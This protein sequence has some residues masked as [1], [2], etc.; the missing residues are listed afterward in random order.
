MY[1]PLHI[2]ISVKRL[3]AA[4]LVCL[5]INM[6]DLTFKFESA[7][8]CL[9]PE[10]RFIG[11]SP[12]SGGELATNGLIVL[13]YSAA[14]FANYQVTVNGISARF[15]LVEL[16]GINRQD[17]GYI[18]PAPNVGDQV[19]LTIED[20]FSGNT[21]INYTITEANDSQ[22]PEASP[23]AMF[24]RDTAVNSDFLTSCDPPNLK[25]RRQERIFAWLNEEE[26]QQARFIKYNGRIYDIPELNEIIR[27]GQ[28]YQEWTLDRYMTI[29][30]EIAPAPSCTSFNYISANGSISEDI[31]ICTACT[32]VSYDNMMMLTQRQENREHCIHHDLRPYD[33]LASDPG[34]ELEQ[35]GMEAGAEAGAEG[36]ADAG[37]EAGAEAGVEAG[38]ESG[39]EAGEIVVNE[40]GI[41]AG[42]E[43]SETMMDQQDLLE[44]E[45]SGGMT[46][47]SA[48]E[49]I[50]DE[51]MNSSESKAYSSCDVHS[52]KHQT[53]YWFLS[54]L[55]LLGLKKEH[56][57]NGLR[58]NS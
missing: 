6:I 2:I 10:P 39:T 35:A 53:N 27:L 55:I 13:S 34:P 43:N 7:S 54:L 37:T 44:E 16:D 52:S 22:A 31:S 5:N 42:N 20:L 8:A 51:T 49:I 33:M 21:I 47:A 36:G 23:A 18:M 4:C 9:P 40:A 41:M 50:D 24:V 56:H 28:T 57:F 48:E 32:Q 3:I 1:R 38:A 26:R 15:D 46:D 11:A 19:S 14:P 45:M 17:L 12:A 58:R 29:S 25:H 30:D